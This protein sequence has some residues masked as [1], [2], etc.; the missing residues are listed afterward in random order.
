MP[1]NAEWA[2]SILLPIPLTWYASYF[3]QN[4]AESSSK[5]PSYTLFF[6]LYI[7]LD[8]S[9]S[10]LFHTLLLTPTRYVARL[11]PGAKV[12]PWDREEEWRKQEEQSNDDSIVWP[13]EEALT[14]LPG[15]WIAKR[16][17]NNF[18]CKMDVPT[19]DGGRTQKKRAK[20]DNKD[21]QYMNTNQFNSKQTQPYFLN[22]VRGSTRIRQASQRVSAALGTVSST[23]IL[24]SFASS[25]LT[26][27]DIGLDTASRNVLFDL[28]C[29]FLIGAFV[30][31]FVFVVE[32]ALGW[33]KVIVSSASTNP[34]LMA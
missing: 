8:A 23:L 28:S 27:R 10:Q 32:L 25:F 16:H 30:V 17:D 24:C 7:F 33:V 26:L 31:S 14:K 34:V 15:D 3:L 29:G 20:R 13:S 19:A 11:L 2:I 21:K 6:L 4:D 9:Y 18:N 12:P 22:H 1:S 5:P